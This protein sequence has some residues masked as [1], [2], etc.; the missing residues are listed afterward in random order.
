MAIRNVITFV[1]T[2]RPVQPPTNPRLNREPSRA[3]VVQSGVRT[4]G[5]F[6]EL[7]NSKKVIDFRNLG[8]GAVKLSKSLGISVN[9]TI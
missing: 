4:Y 3:G 8:K 5:E 9:V 6:V 1:G 7:A 2:G